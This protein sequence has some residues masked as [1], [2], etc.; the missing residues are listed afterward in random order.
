M[1]RKFTE[2]WRRE[3]GLAAAK[4]RAQR[5]AALDSVRIDLEEWADYGDP[6]LLDKCIARL[7]EER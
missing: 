3:F 2:I 5:K 7:E 1:G 6:L 4:A